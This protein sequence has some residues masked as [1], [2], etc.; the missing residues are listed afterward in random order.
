MAY[1]YSSKKLS[2]KKSLAKTRQM[3]PRLLLASLVMAAGVFAYPLDLGEAAIV[4]ENGAVLDASGLVHD[5]DP[6]KVVS[7]DFAYN[8]FK[9]FDL[10]QGHIANLKFGDASTLANLVNNQININGIVNAVRNGKIDGNLI[11]LSP[12][13]IAV[14]ASGVI[15]A[16]QFT[17]LVPTRNAF[18]TLYN[19]PANITLAAVNSLNTGSY[20]N[21][22]SIDIKGQVNTHSGVML[23]A[24]I[25]NINDG[26]KIRSTK[27]LDFNSL[28]NISGGVS[29]GLNGLTA[30]QG[31][32]GDIIITAKETSNV[33]DTNPIRW[34][35]RSTDL[36]AAIN[37][38]K[39]AQ[40]NGV[41]ITS[42]DGTVKLT[43]ASTSTYED[44][45]PMT[46]TDT[47]KGM[48]FGEDSALEGTIDKLA[49]NE[50]GANKYLFVNYSS[51]KNKSSVNIGTNSTITSK[52]IDIA[53]TSQ[54]EI[55]QS[56]AVPS[57]GKDS[58]GNTVGNTSALPVAAVAISRVYNTADIV[59][60]GN[61][62][63]SGANG[64]GDGI[65]ISA[66]A[67]TKA[68]LSATAG[69]GVN[70]SAVVGMAVLTGDTKSRVTVNAPATGTTALTAT[71]GKVSIGAGTTSDINVDVKAVGATSYV[72][73]NVGL[74]NYDTNADVTMNCSI[75]AGAVDIK[76]AN[77][78]TGLKLTVNNEAKSDASAKKETAQAD[79]DQ[80]SEDDT[81]ANAEKN[82]PDSEKSQDEKNSEQKS[83]D[84][85]KVVKD[86]NVD[87][88]DE[89]AK[90]ATGT[91]GKGGIKDIKDKV[92]GTN[93][94]GD[95]ANNYSAF[96]LGAA[97]GVVS[98]K[99]DA[100]ITIGKNAVI[101]A[102]KVSD[103]VDG[104]VK[105]A[106]DSLMT[107]T[108]DNENSLGFTVKNTQANSD[109]VEIGAAVLVSN[110]KNNANIVLDSEGDKSAQIKG[111][112]VSMDASAGMGKYKK[113]NKDTNS[114][115]SYEVSSE[116]QANKVTPAT[117][118]LDG[119][120]GINTL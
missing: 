92:E 63:A 76:A 68:E 44:S 86:A 1:G 40:T 74:V 93:E 29:A 101:T 105:V 54:V 4:R 46:L 106:A 37:I 23:G 104:S 39:D 67:D 53:A 69:G 13:G 11:F 62:T 52:D 99:N 31:A 25:I 57:Q 96:G 61:L 33:K 43:A 48:I 51:K 2:N 59:I 6:E 56:V 94:G 95:N 71:Q 12:D 78:T 114:V 22:K 118:V 47:L 45:T 89:K 66:N 112:A 38:G 3:E 60:D 110:V 120:V 70:T 20:A 100:N 113:D 14:G 28:V 7:N 26:A 90:D 18:D 73:S 81:A 79:S 55:K 34:S 58:N 80:Q 49:S 35:E 77:N 83:I 17:G 72:V 117:V 32:G 85:T 88:N 10:N 15:N 21:A 82:K 119:S 30:S 108:K 9:E 41:Q 97:V 27:D 116:G 5:I 8:R 87:T 111:E 36:S 102:T 42:S 115:L 50:A 75:N 91:D 103:T 98:N 65:K 109:K 19:T 107:A 64:D 16:G 84:P 24:G